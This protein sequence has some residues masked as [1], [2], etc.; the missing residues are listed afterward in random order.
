MA[1]APARWHRKLH[2]LR[3][4][5]APHPINSLWM[6]T[7]NRCTQSFFFS[8]LVMALAPSW[9]EPAAAQ[10]QQPLPQG[11]R[12]FPAAAKR[13]TLTVRT[14]PDV[15]LNGSPERLAPGA[16]IRGVTNTLVMSGSLVGQTYIVNYVR[17]PQGLIKDV[18][19]LTELEVAEKRSGME[20]IINF[21]FGSMG[22]KPKTD[23]GKT[24]Y[25]QLPKFPKQ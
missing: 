7:M 6:N 23:D 19:L 22:D 17:E 2:Y 16:R 11:V 8:V 13:A 14:P 9:P 5:A 10:Q 4:A 1:G 24:P 21:T 20:P 12:Q 18:W 15:L 25:D 3:Q